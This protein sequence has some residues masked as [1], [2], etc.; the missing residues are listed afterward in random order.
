MRYIAAIF[1]FWS[2]FYILSFAKYNLKQK[3]KIAA[4]GAILLAFLIIIL[5]IIVLFINAS[6]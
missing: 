4:A 5:P 6:N 3:N 1:I 2:V